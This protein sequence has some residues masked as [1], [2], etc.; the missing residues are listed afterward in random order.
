MKCGWSK[1][2]KTETDFE[3]VNLIYVGATFFKFVSDKSETGDR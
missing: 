2:D 3:K 1:L